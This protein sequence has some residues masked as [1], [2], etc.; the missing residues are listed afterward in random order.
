MTHDRLV[1]SYTVDAGF[2][3]ARLTVVAEAPGGLPPW[4]ISLGFDRR[5]LARDDFTA[6]EVRGTLR[7]DA[8]RLTGSRTP[9]FPEPVVD[10]MARAIGDEIVGRL[11]AAAGVA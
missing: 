4:V 7:V 6:S 5:L 9:P 8:A 2:H 1:V 10:A 3:G 11:R